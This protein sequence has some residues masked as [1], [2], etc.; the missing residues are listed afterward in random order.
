M[1]DVHIFLDWITRNFPA[2]T[3]MYFPHQLFTH[4]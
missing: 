1:N 4:L 2:L 3:I